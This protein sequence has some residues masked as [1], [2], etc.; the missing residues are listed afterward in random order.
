MTIGKKIIGGYAVVL[1][2]LAIVMFVAFYSL[3]RVQVTYNRFLDVNERLVDGANE[4]RFLARDQTAHYRGILLYPDLQKQY[5]DKLEA[6]YRQFKEILERMRR[7]VF[8]KE[9]LDMV[10]EI[11]ALEAKIEQGEQRVIDLAQRGKRAEALALGIEEVRPVTETMIE[12]VDA[13]RER[14]L[15]L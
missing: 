3:D 15:K 11:A 2:L 14:E 6:D 7:L 1:A 12:K 8:A 10:N 9:G 13:L 5:R 4:I